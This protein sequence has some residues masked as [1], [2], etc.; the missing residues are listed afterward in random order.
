MNEIIWPDIK[1]FRAR[2]FDSPGSPGS[3]VHMNLAFVHKLDKLREAVKM[4]L[5]IHSGYR[6]PEHNATLANSVAGS[7]HTSGHAADLRALDSATKFRILEAAF[8][9]GFRRV[10]IGKDFVHIDDD[11]TKPQ[12]V[13]WLYP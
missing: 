7:A 1:Y 3:G 8:R 5:V 6:T 11:V 2:E 12:D 9:L 13:S 10:G 4:P